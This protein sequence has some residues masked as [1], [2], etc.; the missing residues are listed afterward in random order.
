[1]TPPIKRHERLDRLAITLLITCCAFWGLQQILIKSTLPE[2][3]AMWQAAMRFWIATVLLWLWCLWR[4]IPL[5]NADKTL[6]AGLL[7]GGL[8]AAEFIGIYGGLSYTNAS[9]LTVFLY[10]SVFVVALLLPRFVPSERLNLKQW[11]GL[12]T[13]FCAVAVAFSEGLLSADTGHW[14]GDLLAIAAAIFWGL[15]TLVLRVT[16][17]SQASAEKALFYQIAIAAA[18]TTIASLVVNEPWTL[19]YSS[20][21]WW[22]LALQSVVGA[23]VSYLTWMWMLRHYPATRMASFTFLTP[24]FAL[25]F[26]VGFLGEHLSWQLLV[27]IVG[28]AAGIWLVN[29]KGRPQTL[30]TK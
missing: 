30:G 13:A 11:I 3:P 20:Y 1:M 7:A 10:S 5:F 17:L 29:Q 4:G 24:V 8:F 16:R 23:F 25:I 18:V 27:A 15:T 9:R 12:V 22:S 19:D 26:G 14:R 2:I 6:G 28:V 21:A